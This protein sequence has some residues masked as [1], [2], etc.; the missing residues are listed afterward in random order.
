MGWKRAS[1]YSADRVTLLSSLSTVNNSNEPSSLRSLVGCATRTWHEDVDLLSSLDDLRI[2]PTKAS[3]L[4][5]VVA[6]A[7]ALGNDGEPKKKA[8]CVIM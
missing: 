5:A 1:K 6:A 4:A 3:E 2:E 8:C 7:N